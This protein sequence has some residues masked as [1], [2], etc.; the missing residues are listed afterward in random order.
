MLYALTL[1]Q[2]YAGDSEAVAVIQVTPLPLI[3]FSSG[4]LYGTDLTV[5]LTIVL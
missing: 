2:L 4:L 5:G 3:L 1:L